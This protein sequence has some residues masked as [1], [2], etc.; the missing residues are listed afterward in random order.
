MIRGS[1][2]LPPLLWG[3]RARAADVFERKFLFFYADGGW[4]PAAVFDPHFGSEVVSMDADTELGTVGGISYTSGEGRDLV[5]T[6]LRRWGDRTCFINGLDAHT[7]GHSTGREFTLTGQAGGSSPD[8]G[9]I[10]AASARREYALPYV[11]MSGPAYPGSRGDLLVRGSAGSL[12]S[13]LDHQLVGS[14]DVYSAPFTAPSERLVSDYLAE[15]GA[16]FDTARGVGAAGART[17]AWLDGLTRMGELERRAV[18]LNFSSTSSSTIE[19][20]LNAVELFRLD[21]AR[22]VMI[23]VEGFWDTHNS[24]SLQGPQLNTFFGALDELM[25]SLALTPGVQRASLLD[26]VVVVALSDFGRTPSE[27]GDGGKDHWPFGS[28]MILGSGVAGDQAVG[29]TDDSLV[30]QPIDLAT[31][32]PDSAGD[33]PGVENLGAAL[34]LLGGQDPQPW[35]PDV[36]PL[37]A[38]LRA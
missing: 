3:A 21:L 26:E 4:D 22:V 16:A 2:A 31:G 8:W 36:Q 15:R 28:A 11:V 19:Q 10:L 1:L 25:Q 37:R 13:L 38:A 34:L 32:A 33:I 7:I 18:E 23:S 14:L 27:N 20:A 24:N 30:S 35:L 9:T 29:Y 17:G 6:F 12:L 5:T